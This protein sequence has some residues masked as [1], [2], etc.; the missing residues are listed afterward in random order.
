MAAA[1]AGEPSRALVAVAA[2]STVDH[3]TTA[4]RLPHVETATHACRWLS[5][6]AARHRRGLRAWFTAGAAAGLAAGAASVAVLLAEA[7]TL[8]QPMFTSP[9]EAAVQPPPRLALALP[10]VTLPAS[11]AAPL[12]LALAASLVVHEVCAA[13]VFAVGFR[14]RFML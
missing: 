9:T 6:A 12:W 13:A 10:G 14:K 2:A 11:H 7:A 8:L 4:E 1:A 3:C 5:R